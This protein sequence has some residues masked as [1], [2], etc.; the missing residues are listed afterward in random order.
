MLGT[1]G[2][3]TLAS[4]GE[5]GQVRQQEYAAIVSGVHDDGKLDIHVFF[6]H[7][8]SMPV[9]LKRN[10]SVG[11]GEPGTFSPADA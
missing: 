5:I 2:T 6:T 10:V 9:A 4:D 11:D 3:Y 8:P 7:I 1:V